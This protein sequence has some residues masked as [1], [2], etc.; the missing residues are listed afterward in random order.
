[1]MA[2]N[3]AG[4]IAPDQIIREQLHRLRTLPQPILRVA[5]RIIH[6]LDDGLRVAPWKGS[7][8]P[9]AGHC[10]VASE[11]AQ[12]LL[13]RV[14]KL[15]RLNHKGIIHWYLWHRDDGILLDLTSAQFKD[16]PDYR[17]GSVAG[18]LPQTPCRRT[19]MLLQRLK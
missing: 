13:G 7:L 14:W 8:N 17:T 6:S 3:P 5:T 2:T 16:V 1:M 11:A 19:R 15:C 4:V 12:Y 10:Y 18:F 9:L